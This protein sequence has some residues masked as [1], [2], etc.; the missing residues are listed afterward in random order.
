M[1][2]YLDHPGPI[3]FAHR[4]GAAGGVENALSAFTAVQALGYRFVETDVR[5]TRD[6]VALVFHDADT[7]RLTGTP[8]RVSALT[9]VQVRRLALSGGEP[10]PTLEEALEAFPDLRFNVDLK[11]EGGVGAV[12][13]VLARTRAYGRVCVTSFSQ[14][15][16]ERARRLLPAGACLGLGVGGVAQLLALRRACGASVLQLP[17]SLGGGRTLPRWAVAL[18]QRHGLAV[19]VWTV[20]EPDAMRAALDLGVDGVMTDRPAVLR[21]VLRER[22]QWHR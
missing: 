22:G 13:A 9:A 16:I 5:T 21:D 6:G 17:W 20:D 12:P 4:G 2:P 1:H 10:V 14:R 19:H 3:P 18:G 11:D 15:R 8:G 7:R